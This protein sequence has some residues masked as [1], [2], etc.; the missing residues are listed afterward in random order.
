MKRRTKAVLI[1]G[2][3]TVATVVTAF[4]MLN[5]A[6]A[7]VV[8]PTHQC[9]S[10]YS[11]LVDCSYRRFSQTIR[12][13]TPV[14][15][16]STPYRFQPTYTDTTSWAVV[17]CPQNAVARRLL[18]A[19]PAAAAAADG[20]M[21]DSS[22][23]LPLPRPWLL[24]TAR[25]SRF[26]TSLH[27]ETPLALASTL[28]FY[29]AE[30]GKRGWTENDNAVVAPDR[31][32]IAFTT[33]DGPALLRLIHQADRTIVD[34][35]LH[36]P[37]EADDAILPKPGQVRLRLGN[38]TDEETVVT[39]NE[40]TIELAARTGDKLTDNP[41]TGRQAPGAHEID[42]PP[43]KYKVALKLASGVTQNG[44]FEVAA[45]ETWGLVVGKAGVLLPVQL[46]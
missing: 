25:D 24:R 37:A 12:Q 15:P 6:F 42:L 21:D 46:Y 20:G 7:R 32:A 26:I 2:L 14:F 28:G 39:I 16:S 11:T 10:G 41:E 44:A 9:G 3:A 34:L 4:V 30:L 17:D 40:Q 5:A 35:S 1:G 8:D 33:K 43:G 18:C 23:G 45:G 27:V 36:K 31:A 19:V 38:S 13:G 29:R 22:T